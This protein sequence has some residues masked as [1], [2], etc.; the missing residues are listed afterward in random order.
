MSINVNTMYSLT[1]LGVVRI[2]NYPT[3]TKSSLNRQNVFNNTKCITVGLLTTD[4]RSSSYLSPSQSLQS[5]HDESRCSAYKPSS[6]DLASS[7]D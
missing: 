2:L 7:A 1:F 5:L 3:H 6:M 4:Q